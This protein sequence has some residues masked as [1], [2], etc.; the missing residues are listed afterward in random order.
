MWR[1]VTKAS[2]EKRCMSSSALWTKHSPRIRQGT[3]PDEVADRDGAQALL[4]QS[5]AV[6]RVG[7][8]GR[9]WVPEKVNGYRSGEECV[10]PPDLSVGTT[11]RE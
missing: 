8:E 11:D 1:A 5:D 9:G 2:C 7:G 4:R 6:Q 10:R 3:D